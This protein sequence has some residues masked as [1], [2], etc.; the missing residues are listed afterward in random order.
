MDKQ[1]NLLVGTYNLNPS[2]VDEAPIL[3]Q[4]CVPKNVRLHAEL[5]SRKR[6]FFWTPC[7]NQKRANLENPIFVSVVVK[8]DKLPLS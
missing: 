5:P 4:Y 8:K 1:G 6:T 3:I 2:L 7:N